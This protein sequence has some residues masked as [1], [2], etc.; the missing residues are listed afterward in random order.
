MGIL[1][2]DKP[3][4]PK[5][6]PHN[7][8]IF[9][10]PMAGK[11][12]FASYF[13]HPLVLN[14]DGNASQGTAPSIQLRN[15]RGKDGKLTQNVMKQIDEVV[16]ELQS[17]QTTFKTI[18]IDVIED[19]CVMVE[20]AICIEAGV[21][22]LGDIPYGKG[23]STMKSVLQ[24]FVMDLKALPMDV[25]FIS[26][27][28]EVTDEKT[29]ATEI[30]SGLKD[31]YYNIVTGN[32]DLTIRCQKLGQGKYARIVKDKRADYKPEDISDKR[33]KDLLSSC[34]GMF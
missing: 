32:C 7:F 3:V 31:S 28:I 16:L 10:R 21:D 25:I 6:E 30:K 4:K 17:Q 8:Y 20:Q 22:A 23:F 29:G 2:E 27:E 1:P 19:V 14:T 18:I 13:P 11:S 9:G 12:Y 33:I 26:R 5:L 24:R 34:I 15:I